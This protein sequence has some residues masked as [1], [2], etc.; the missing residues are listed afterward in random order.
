MNISGKSFIAML[1]GDAAGVID[2]IDYLRSQ[3]A[4]Q[5]GWL[6]HG[7]E[8]G[9][10]LL[11]Q[12]DFVEH[13]DDR[14]HYRISAAPGTAAYAGYSLGVSFAG[15]LG[16]YP[17]RTGTDY[18]KVELIASGPEPDTFEF[19]LRDSRGYR[20]GIK[21]DRR[22]NFYVGFG[23]KSSERVRFLN[24]EKGDFVHFGAKIIRYL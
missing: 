4:G 18:W 6:V 1:Q 16:F 9:H 10:A 20:V 23:R 8:S 22:G 24:V 14:I 7:V 15:Y 5:S 11:L 17:S 12:F 21:E 3:D 19:L 2:A 13:I